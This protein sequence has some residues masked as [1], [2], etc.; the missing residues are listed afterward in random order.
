MNPEG[1]KSSL[2]AQT[3]AGLCPTAR[4]PSGRPPQQGIDSRDWVSW[5]HLLSHVQWLMLVVSWATRADV[6]LWA[7]QGPGPRVEVPGVCGVAEGEG[8]RVLH[9]PLSR[10][11]LG[12]SALE[13]GEMPG[14]EAFSQD[15]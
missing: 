4:A 9:R 12:L 15:T 6:E 3:G 10:A 11:G 14:R 7:P 2:R 13:C 8:L 5:R 1:R